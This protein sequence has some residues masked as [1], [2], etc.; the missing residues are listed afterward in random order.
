M[1][2]GR[3]G[4]GGTALVWLAPARPSRDKSRAAPDGACSKGAG[5]AGVTVAATHEQSDEILVG[6]IAAG[7]EQ[8][9]TEI[10]RRHAGRIRALALGFSDGAAEA[11]DIVQE[12]FWSLWRN[13]RRWQPGGPPLAAYLARIATN[14]AIDAGRRRRARHFF[15]LDDTNDVA[16]PQPPADRRLA[17]GSELA[18]VVTDIHRLPR[19]QRIAILLAAGGERSNAEIATM[20]GLSLGAAEQL[21]VR[22]RRA[23]RAGLAARDSRGET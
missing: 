6:R 3:A 17:A 7:D 16:D 15:G 8:A 20:M 11:D 23:L 22:A 2:S 13:A 9:F 1:T 21:L 5:S 14:R 19:R 18:A 10:V 12:T 4:A